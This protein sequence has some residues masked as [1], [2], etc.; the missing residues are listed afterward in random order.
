MRFSLRLN[1]DLTVADYVELAQIAEEAGFDQFWVSDDLFLRSAPV[2]LTAVA[3]HT[4]RIEIG[5]CIVNPYTLHP[6]EMAMMA[7]TLD[8]VSNGRFN[9]GLSAGAGDFLDWVGLPH[10]RPYTLTRE[11]LIVL[12]ALFRNERAAIDGHELHWTD[13]AYM[14]FEVKRP[15]P[16]YVGALSPKMLAL[17]G[18]LADGG[19]PLLFPPEHYANVLPHIQRGAADAERPL[20]AVD[21]AACIWVSV[22]DDRDRAETVLKEKIAYY[23]HALSPMIWD[24][25]GVS[26]ADFAPIAHTLQVERDLPRAVSMVTPPMLRIGI[27]GSAHEVIERLE[28]LAALGV[29]HLSFGP[30]LGYDLAG[31]IRTLGREVLP[32]FR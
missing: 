28:S 5:T 30:P 31:A 20:D 29:Q 32:R 12:K 22:G 10:E 19:L 24:A 8:E 11:T 25:L 21:V 16:I 9:L 1:N 17:V 2:I 27:A 13:E 6:A 3:L 15:I 18:E 4:R 26:Q 23:G 7:A 14:R